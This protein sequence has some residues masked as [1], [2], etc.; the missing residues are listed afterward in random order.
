MQVYLQENASFNVFNNE[1]F[2][3]QPGVITG[4]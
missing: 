1:G 2:G 4:P 3:K